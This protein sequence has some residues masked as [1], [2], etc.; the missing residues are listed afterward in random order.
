VVFMVSGGSQ[1]I[2]FLLEDVG[3]LSERSFYIKIRAIDNV[4]KIGHCVVTM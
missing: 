4:Q 2:N 3:R 1:L